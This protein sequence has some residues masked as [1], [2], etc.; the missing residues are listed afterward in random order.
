MLLLRRWRPAGAV[1][2]RSRAP[3]VFDLA[4][5]SPPEDLEVGELLLDQRYTAL[6]VALPLVEPLSPLFG[7]SQHSPRSPPG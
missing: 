1:G 4:I 7:I 2:R 3:F 5:A 6:R